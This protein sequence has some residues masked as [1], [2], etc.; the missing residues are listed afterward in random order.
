MKK[1]IQQLTIL[2]KDIKVFAVLKRRKKIFPSDKNLF[3][4]V[5]NPNLYHRFFYLLLKFYQLNGYQIYYPMNFSKFRNL[6][7]GDHYLSLILK[8]DLLLNINHS[9]PV[10][11]IEIRDEHFCADYFKNYFEYN[12]NESNAFHIPM[13]FH[14]NMY[15]LGLWNENIDCEKQRLNALFCYGNFNDK[16]YL[17]IEKTYFKVINRRKLYDFFSTQDCFILLKNKT[18]L[19]KIINSK[20]VGRYIF[21]EKKVYTI[22]INEVRQ[23]LSNFRYFLCCPGVVMPLCHNIIE[24]MSVGTVPVIQREYAEI[25][26]PELQNEKNAIIFE[27]LNELNLKLK[28]RLFDISESEFELLSRNALTY[29]EENLAPA[30]VISKLNESLGKRKI[31]LNA[32]H[33]SVKFKS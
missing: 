23:T 15:H 33:R 1:R 22:P 6:R 20:P 13:G 4:N 30:Q 28:N 16:A 9:L 18:H 29:Y 26:Y 24:A 2:L 27:D 3:V 8:K 19:T 7:N 25:M 12:N 31:Y 17:N 11:Y 14:P 21:A 5:Q 10:D 32:E